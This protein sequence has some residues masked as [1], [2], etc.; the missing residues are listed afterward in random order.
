MPTLGETLILKIHA[1]RWPM[2]AMSHTATKRVC[3][4]VYVTSVA[5]EASNPSPRV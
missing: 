2:C 3:P 1:I 5:F 4:F